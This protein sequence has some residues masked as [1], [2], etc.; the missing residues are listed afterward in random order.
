MVGCLRAKKCNRQDLTS[1]ADVES[2]LMSPE[3]RN[4]I[5]WFDRKTI[6]LN[7][8]QNIR[9]KTGPSGRTV[10][11]SAGFILSPSSETF[12]KRP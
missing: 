7:S 8:L 5:K 4:I 10:A 3:D 6:Q 2:T 9:D 12:Q 11:I 1:K